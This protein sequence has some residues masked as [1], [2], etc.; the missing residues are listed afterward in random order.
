LYRLA[1]VVVISSVQDGMN[2]VVKE[3]IASQGQ[4]PGA[5]CLS[6]FAGA[7]EEMDHS[8]RINP[9]HTEGFADDLYRAI[10]LSTK[11]RRKRMARMKSALRQHTIYTWMADFLAAAGQVREEAASGGRSLTPRA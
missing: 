9:F 8:I 1:D 7:A 5:V 6:E 2:L 10:R 4:D 3:F 11:E